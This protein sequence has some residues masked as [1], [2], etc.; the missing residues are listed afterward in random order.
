MLFRSESRRDYFRMPDKTSRGSPIQAYFSRQNTEGV[1]YV[2]PAP[3]TAVDCIN[4]TYERPIQEV[5]SNTETLDIPDYWHEAFVWNLAK[6]LAV[7]FGCDAFRMAE[8]KEQAALLLDQ[9][10]GFDTDMYPIKVEIRNA[11]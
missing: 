11:Y 4:F 8:I 2:W 3:S 6:R 1:M 10:L 5:S 7:K 9:A